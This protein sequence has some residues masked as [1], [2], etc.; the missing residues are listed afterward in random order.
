MS[1]SQKRPRA[2]ASLAAA[3][4]VAG[5]LQFMPIAAPAASAAE[6]DAVL[7][8]NPAVT[9]PAFD[10]WGTSLVWMA[11]ATGDYPAELRTDLIDTVFGDEGLNLNIARYN[12]G[13]G[14]ASDVA[15][16]LRPGGAVPGWWNAEAPLSDAQGAITSNY[17]DR[18][19][20]L[21]AWSGDAASVSTS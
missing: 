7:T 8:P 9:G 16:Y 18:D 12:I 6:A 15:D 19:R 17:A 1:S 11:N 3:A 2:A 10:G 5:S 20:F 14:N 21:A 4:V 13:G